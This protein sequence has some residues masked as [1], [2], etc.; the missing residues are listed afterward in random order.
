MS[1][2]AAAVGALFADPNSPTRRVG[3]TPNEGFEQIRHP[4]PMLSIDDLSPPT[5]GVGGFDVGFANQPHAY[6][7]TACSKSLR[8]TDRITR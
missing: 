3:G 5:L 6:R 8:Q 1:A 7:P 2:F 4:V